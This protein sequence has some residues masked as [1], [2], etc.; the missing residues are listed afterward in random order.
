MSQDHRPI[1]S[2]FTQVDISAG[3]QAPESDTSK[4]EATELLRDMLLSQDRSN[5]LLEELVRSMGAAQ[6][7]R[8][9]ELNQWKRANP[10][11]A[12]SCRDAAEALSRVQVEYLENLTEEIHSSVDYLMEGEFMLNEFV[13]RFGPR[14]AH[15]NGMIQVLAQLSSS[16]SA[17]GTS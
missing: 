6:K 5:A 14:L 12:Q 7:Q 13:D 9:N 3:N 15:L 11:L 16:P 4:D 1:A 10:Q 8:S 2:M 17:A